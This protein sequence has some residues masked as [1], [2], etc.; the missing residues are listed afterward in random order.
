MRG[1]VAG[2]PWRT[3]NTGQGQLPQQFHIDGTEPP[4]SGHRQVTRMRSHDQIVIRSQH[5]F[6]QYRGWSSDKESCLRFNI[7]YFPYDSR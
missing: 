2:C 4:W 6:D 5:F 1:F 3:S 7:T